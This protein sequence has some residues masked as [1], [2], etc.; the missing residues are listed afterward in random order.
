MLSY[1]YVIGLVAF[2]V[3]FANT[4]TSAK[5][6]K[7]VSGITCGALLWEVHKAFLDTLYFDWNDTIATLLACLTLVTIQYFKPL[8]SAKGSA[9]VPR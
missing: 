8:E 6:N 9:V 1:W 3:T 4:M 7:A 5:L 2:Y